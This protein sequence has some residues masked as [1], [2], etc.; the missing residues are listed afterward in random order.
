MDPTMSQEGR[1][2]D[3]G[4]AYTACLSA[5]GSTVFSIVLAGGADPHTVS[6]VLNH[7]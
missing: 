7:A 2:P 3:I 5:L 1:D 6:R 4:S